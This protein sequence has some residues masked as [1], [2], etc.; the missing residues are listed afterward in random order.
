MKLMKR[1]DERILQ[2]L[3]DRY[4]S[5][6]LYEDKN[7]VN[8]SIFVPINK[9]TMPEYFDETSVAYDIIH[10]QLHELESR[11]YLTLEWGKRKKHILE[12][13]I[14][15]VDFA[16]QI[17]QQL[18]RTPRKEKEQRFLRYCDSL[19]QEYPS[20]VNIQFLHWIDSRIRNGESIK[21]YADLNN[22]EA[23][24][25]LVKIIYSIETNTEDL[26]LRQFSIRCFHDSKIVEQE[27]RKA[28][29]ILMRYSMESAESIEEQASEDTDY[30]TDLN[31]DEILAQYH[32]FR[33]PSW[34]MMKG[35][36]AFL[37]KSS[38]GIMNS[39]H[40]QGFPGGM[41]ISNEDIDKI[42]WI[43][44]VKP[45]YIITIENLTSFHQWRMSDGGLCIYLGGFANESRRKMLKDLYQVYNQVPFYHFG[46]IDCGGFYIWKNL[47]ESTGIPFK[48]RKM[49][50]NTYDSYAEYGK[51][52]T[53][54]DRKQLG[55]M[56]EDPFFIEQKELFEQMLI[57]GKKIEQECIK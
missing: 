56:K 29:G 16:D 51:D 37:M 13:C 46:D 31:L 35:N 2:L 3:L 54:R 52:L 5:S 48:A 44:D 42:S 8:I 23:F 17:Y 22:L 45:S 28:C 25:R 14:L 49:D 7:K 24:E 32:I 27:I 15:N 26:F 41:G 19:R 39:I 53:G 12:K 1:Y 20:R 6:L 40:L 34:L 47:C 4:E 57:R 43:E 38:E 18:H 36:A 11:G 50:L 33:N 30:V 10:E 9:R 21:E 55:L